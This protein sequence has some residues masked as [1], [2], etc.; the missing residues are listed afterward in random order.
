MRRPASRPAA[1]T[2]RSDALSRCVLRCAFLA[3]GVIVAAGGLAAAQEPLEATR[4]GPLTVRPRDPA[5]SPPL[6]DPRARGLISPP[7]VDKVVRTDFAYW[8]VGNIEQTLSRLCSVGKFNQ[9]VP[10][11]FVGHFKGPKGSA[12][13]GAAKGNGLNLFDPQHKADKNHDY[14]FY[15]DRTA[16]CIVFSAAVKPSAAGA[17]RSTLGQGG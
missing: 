6:P 13:L 16:D 11:R 14:W 4:V 2:S 10:Y 17:G 7:A 1:S 5:A 3:A 12:M 15:R 9:R 8:Q